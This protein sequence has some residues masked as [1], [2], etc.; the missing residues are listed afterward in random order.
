MSKQ[1][2][3][4]T[5]QD[6]LKIEIA[7]E[8]GLWGKIQRFGWGELTAEEAGRIGGLMRRRMKEENK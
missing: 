2:K 5:V 1:K 7:Q 3:E 6:L 4:P 8:L